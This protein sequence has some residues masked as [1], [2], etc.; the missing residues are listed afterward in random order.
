MRSFDDVVDQVRGAIL[1]GTILA[2]ER[3]PSERELAEQFGVSRATLR[4]ALRALEAVGL[5]EIRVGAHGGAFATEGG[6]GRTADTFRHAFDVEFATRPGH[7]LQYRAAAHADSV[8][9]ADP[10]GEGLERL[11][12]AIDRGDG[13]F[14]LALA[15]TSRSPIRVALAVALESE[16]PAGS[17]PS[18]TP[19]D[20]REVLDL[21]QRGDR[22]RARALLHRRLSSSVV[23]G[24]DR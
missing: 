19:A 9:W 1:D 5:I 3:L 2:G 8:T 14:L 4:E 22:E 23:P 18:L 12:Q 15:E 17:R 16:H 20:M 10:D 24:D 6:S 13:A 21:L 7:A 11:R